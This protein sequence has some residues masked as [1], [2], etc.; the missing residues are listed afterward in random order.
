MK[1]AIFFLSFLFSFCQT[2]S[3][4]FPIIWGNFQKTSGE[5]VSILPKNNLNF[6]ALRWSGGNTFGSYKLENYESLTF[7]EQKKVKLNTLSG[8]GT[9]EKV[10][11]FGDKACVFLS[12]FANGRMML[13]MQK[14]NDYLDP[15][16]EPQLLAD[17]ENRKFNSKPNFQIV[18]SNNN[19]FLSVFWQIP[20]KSIQSDS[21]GYKIYN[22]NFIEIH[23]GE[24]AIPIDGNLTIINNYHLTDQGDCLISVSEY[25]KSVDRLFANNNEN[26][27]AL[28]IYKLKNNVLSEF[29]LNTEG[30]RVE[31]LRLNSNDSSTYSLIGLYSKGNLRSV[32]GICTLQIDAVHDTIKS[33]GFIPLSIASGGDKWGNDSQF[34]GQNFGRSQNSSN[35]NRYTY[36][37]RDIFIQNDGSILAS[38]EE[39]YLY[40]RVNVDN[41]SGISTSVNYYY[42]DDIIAI[43]INNKNGLD[44]ENRIQKS[45]VS[46]ND[47]GVYS[48]FSSFV[49]DTNF[50]FIFN[51]NSLNYD[52][53]GVYKKEN[54]K[55]TAHNF[56]RQRNASTLV[57]IDF[58]NGKNSRKT[59]ISKNELDGLLIPKMFVLNTA[60]KELLVVAYQGFKEKF[61]YIKLNERK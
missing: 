29:S 60:N 30:L 11:Y 26:F 50:C 6:L 14:Y 24:Y 27:K 4:E 7:L 36:K 47:Q 23:A 18:T 52:D 21:Y 43:K 16:E 53:Q 38:I 20:G 8:I 22:S 15:E 44:W 37:L 58:K 45:Q 19:K 1:K 34:L 25:T 17:Y 32:T 49:K 57:Q 42:Y 5:L 28:H 3:Q 2:Y 55:P 48:S 61:G 54:S 41:R 12:D 51:D 9:F 46:V 31:E 40:R 56:M 39:Y 59:F 35:S 10:F 33:S 13:F